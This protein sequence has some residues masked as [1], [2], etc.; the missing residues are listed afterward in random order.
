M[1]ISSTEIKNI[2]SELISEISTE[3]VGYVYA[4]DRKKDPKSI[5]GER[6]R[7]KYQSDGDLK[8]HGNTETSAV[9][10]MWAD[11]G[12]Q[13]MN[14]NDNAGINRK[15]TGRIIE[16]GADTALVDLYTGGG[17][18]SNLGSL[19]SVGGAMS[20]NSIS[21]GCL[22]EGYSDSLRTAYM[23]AKKTGNA[24]ALVYYD[25]LAKLPALS[26]FASYDQFKGSHL[27]EKWKVKNVNNIEEKKKEITRFRF[28]EGKV[29]KSELKEIIKELVS[30]T[31]NHTLNEIEEGIPLQKNKDFIS[32]LIFRLKEGQYIW[33]SSDKH[34]TSENGYGI[35]KK[36][37]GDEYVYK[38]TDKHPEYLEQEEDIQ[39]FAEEIAEDKYVNFYLIL[40]IQGYNLHHSNH[41]DDQALGSYELNGADR[42]EPQFETTNISNYNK[43][44][45]EII[46]QMKD[47]IKDCQWIDIS[48]ESGVDEFSISEIL[49]GIEEHYDGGIKGFLA[50]LNEVDKLNESIEK[51]VAQNNWGERQELSAMKRIQAYAKWGKASLTKNRAD[52]SI[53]F[54]RII[55]EIDGLVT[56]HEHGKEVP[57][58][59][60]NK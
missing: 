57:T 49:K 11:I 4:K 2:I 35:E 59:S 3:G 14:N 17:K 55:K 24:E 56:A 31:F 30:E 12:N 48:D 41:E 58:E 43:L 47:W 13:S 32:N 27:Y 46:N 45:P 39:K 20:E 38:T 18:S 33:F 9:N 34:G 51:N 8:K 54:D 37:E 15:P 42:P 36:V 22:K 25:Q 44:S 6:W 52:M 19:P 29:L 53:I 21:K 28:Q 10:E 50:S 1:N 23:K 60:I 26:A 5:T 16:P 40:P 7:I